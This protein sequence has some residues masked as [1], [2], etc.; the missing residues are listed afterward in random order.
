M[1]PATKRLTG[2]VVEVL[3]GVD[4]LEHALRMTAMRSP[5]VIA[6]VWSWVT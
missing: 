6:S 4:L 5:S 1:K 3:R 2:C